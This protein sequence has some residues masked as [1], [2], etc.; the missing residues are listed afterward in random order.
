MG[1]VICLGAWTPARSIASIVEHTQS[2]VQH[3]RPHVAHRMMLGQMDLTP[4]ARSESRSVSSSE[5]LASH[6]M[7]GNFLINVDLGQ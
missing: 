1:V 4:L 6:T 5:T 7:P 2:P 3:P